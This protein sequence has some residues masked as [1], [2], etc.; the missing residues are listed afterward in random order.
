M[1]AK[2]IALMDFRFADVE[3]LNVE[4]EDELINKIKESDVI[5]I[6]NGGEIYGVNSNYIMW[7]M[8]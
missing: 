5:Q 2:F 8:L 4:N 1:K 7:Y 6:K 3:L